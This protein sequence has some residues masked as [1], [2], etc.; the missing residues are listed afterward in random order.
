MVRLTMVDLNEYLRQQDY[1]EY[2]PQAVMMMFAL[3]RQYDCN[4][5]LLS[6]WLSSTY[7][8][9]LAKYQKVRMPDLDLSK[10][11]FQS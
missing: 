10:R 6:K 7:K 11:K 9:I 3:L 8:E 4:S 5:N 1:T 2:S